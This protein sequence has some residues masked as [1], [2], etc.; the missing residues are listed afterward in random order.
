MTCVVGIEADG[1][2]YMGAD[3]AGSVDD[4]IVTRADEKVFIHPTKELIVGFSGSFRVFQVLRYMFVPPKDPESNND[5]DGMSY[6]VV[7]FIPA[8]RALFTDQGVLEREEGCDMI[9]ETLLVGRAGKLY[10]IDSDFQVARFVD[11]FAAIGEGTQTALGALYA[12][13]NSCKRPEERLRLALEA[14][15]E[16]NMTV[17]GPFNILHL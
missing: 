16:Y 15:A 12:T 11:R 6:M 13:R 2:V 8:L 3:T 4:R 1:V 14:A 5:D 7:N 17:R 9:N 10:M